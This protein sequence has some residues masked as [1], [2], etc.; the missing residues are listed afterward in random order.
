MLASERMFERKTEPPSAAPGSDEELL[1]Q[2]TRGNRAALAALYRRH[3][4]LVQTLALR[5]LRSET[6][7]RD[8]VQ[9]VFLEVWRHAASYD[10]S[11]GP[12]RG[13]LLLRTR[14]RALD[15]LKS[16]GRANTVALEDSEAPILVTAPE[17]QD[18]AVDARRLP[19]ALTKVSE[20]EREVLCLG[21]FE[22][23]SSSEIAERVGV[24]LGTV[25]SRTRSA[26][27]KIRTLLGEGQ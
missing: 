10:P 11:R 25:K 6:E 22:G 7:A 14:S 13:W 21:Y 1:L 5:V 26:L 9:D 17:Q 4:P 27:E 2:L 16:K 8:L 12:V 20:Q 19:S 15:R 23:L 18:H 3:A 24:P